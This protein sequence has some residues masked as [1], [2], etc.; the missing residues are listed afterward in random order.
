MIW[1]SLQWLKVIVS[2]VK[3][4][5]GCSDWSCVSPPPIFLRP[6]IGQQSCPFKVTG[7]YNIWYELFNI[8]YYTT[9]H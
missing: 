7:H 4:P 5:H 8:T 9:F 6:V 2:C 3:I 1:I